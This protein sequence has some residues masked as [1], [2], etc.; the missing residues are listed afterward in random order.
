MRST[1]LTVTTGGTDRVEKD[2]EFIISKK[3]NVVLICTWIKVSRE[4][5]TM[6]DGSKEEELKIRLTDN[7]S[8]VGAMLNTRIIPLASHYGLM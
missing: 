4:G 6:E 1:V 3:L 5:P 8:S 7:G 2:D